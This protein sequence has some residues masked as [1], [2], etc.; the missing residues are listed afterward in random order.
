[1]LESAE[2]RRA[3]LHHQCFER[4]VK[5]RSVRHNHDP[6][7]AGEM[8]VRGLDQHLVKPPGKVNIEAAR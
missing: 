3:W 5:Q 2:N 6:A 7:R 8:C 1:M 4:Q